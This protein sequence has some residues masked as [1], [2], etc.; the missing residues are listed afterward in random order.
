MVVL[1]MEPE[2]MTGDLYCLRPVTRARESQLERNSPVCETN[3][4]EVEAFDE[5]VLRNINSERDSAPQNRMR[6]QI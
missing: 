6:F 4:S 1:Q 5:E 3:E 2:E